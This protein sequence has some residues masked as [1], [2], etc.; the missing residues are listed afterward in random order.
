MN[1]LRCIIVLELATALG[2]GQAGQPS[3]PSG[4]SKQPETLVRNLYKEVV[5]RHPRG[6]PEGADMKIFAPYLSKALQ[7]RID[8]AGACYDDW[9]RLLSRVCEAHVGGAAPG[10]LA[11]CS[12]CTPAKRPFRR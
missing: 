11:G 6:I 4:L 7:H 5:A 2:L 12:N 9:I 10:D 3:Q 1:L 8:V